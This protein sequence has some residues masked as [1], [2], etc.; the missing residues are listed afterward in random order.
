MKGRDHQLRPAFCHAISKPPPRISAR[1]KSDHARTSVRV[2]HAC[3]SITVSTRYAWLPY[4]L[5]WITWPE[6]RG[7]FAASLRYLSRTGARRRRV[8]LW[9]KENRPAAHDMTHPIHAARISLKEW[10]LLYEKETFSRARQGRGNSLRAKKKRQKTRL[11]KG[12]DPR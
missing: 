10:E 7:R 5:I 4:A 3:P 2:S 6:R 8:K 12:Q 1:T 11:S 9:H